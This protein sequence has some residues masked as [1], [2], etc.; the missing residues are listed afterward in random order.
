MKVFTTGTSPRRG[1][2]DPLQVFRHDAAMFRVG[3]ERVRVI[4]QAGDGHAVLAQQFAHAAGVVVA[5][6]RHVE[7]GDAGVAAVGAAG[8][9]AHQ[10]HAGE[11]LVM[12]EGQ[13]L[14]QR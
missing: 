14:F 2:H 11:A 8:R 10:F 12:R 4:A 6:A 5:E 13:H 9:P 7:M 1:V 3:I